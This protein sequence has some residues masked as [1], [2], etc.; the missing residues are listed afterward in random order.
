M[1]NEQNPSSDTPEL[2]QAQFDLLVETIVARRKAG[3]SY[4]RIRADIEAIG[5]PLEQSMWNTLVF[6]AAFEKVLGKRKPV[7]KSPVDE[8]P[9]LPVIARI[10]AAYGYPKEEENTAITIRR[11]DGK[12]EMKENKQ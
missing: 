7:K 2:T 12:W 6:I 8:R 4:D 11:T 1:K 3:E 9:G 10:F 5:T